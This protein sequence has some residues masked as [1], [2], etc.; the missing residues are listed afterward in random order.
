MRHLGHPTRTMEVASGLFNW[1]GWVWVSSELS[2]IET[3]ELLGDTSE[4]AD[5][6]GDSTWGFALGGDRFSFKSSGGLAFLFIFLYPLLY[7][8]S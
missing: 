1:W 7:L 2:S 6:F 5:N 3:H 8:K 4:E